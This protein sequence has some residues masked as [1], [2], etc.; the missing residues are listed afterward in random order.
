MDL[1]MPDGDWDE[2]DEAWDALTTH[3]FSSL[4]A[5]LARGMLLDFNGLRSDLETWNAFIA[6]DGAGQ[7]RY[8]WHAAQ[9]LIWCAEQAAG[10]S[11][12]NWD[13]IDRLRLVLADSPDLIKGL[14][15]WA[16]DC[17]RVLRKVHR[18]V[19]PVQV[20]I[21]LSDEL[22]QSQ[23]SLA[24]LVVETLKPGGG[25]V[26]LHP[27][28]GLRTYPHAD[29]E[30]S[31]QAAWAAAR[32]LAEKEEDTDVLFDGRWRLLLQDQPIEEIRGRS[33]S[34]AAALG[35][36]HALRGTVPDERVI[37]LAQVDRAG[38]LTGVEGVPAKVRAIAAGGRFDTIVVAGEENQREAEDILR[39]LGKLDIIRVK[40]LHDRS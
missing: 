7:K 6:F 16:M 22:V 8:Q 36:Y 1:K 3:L 12:N 19:R 10:L 9:R 40:N 30:S 31:M 4:Q 11:G 15:G 39:G 28:D 17:I 25:Q 26:F 34:G 27:A 23:A 14:E 32:A 35:W 37:V 18:P 24:T 13:E 20:P 29:F 2:Q 21:A 5:A 38:R 33:A